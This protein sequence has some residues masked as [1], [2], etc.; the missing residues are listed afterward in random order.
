[1]LDK[2]DLLTLTEVAELLHVSK[3]HVSNVVLG[4]VA[5]CSPMPAL[6]LGRR[7]LICRSSLESWILENDRVAN[8][9]RKA[10]ANDNCKPANDNRKPVA[11]ITTSPERGRRSA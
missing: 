5:G 3:A 4:R 2:L 10:A 1:M 8:D 7:T 9:S 11:K 6:R